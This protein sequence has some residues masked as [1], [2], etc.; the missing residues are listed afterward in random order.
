MRSAGQ[1]EDLSR[2]LIIGA[3]R[4]G[5]AAALLA[6]RM[7]PQV[8]IV[9]C[10]RQLDPGT[11]AALATLE[12]AKVKLKLGKEDNTLLDGC[13]LVI[14]SP[15]VPPDISL[16]GEARRR[17]IP[18]WGEVEFAWRF[19]ENPV[20]GV[21][22]TNGK[23]TTTELIGH[24]LKT[25]GWACRV[26]GNVGT[27]LSS[28]VGEMGGDEIVVLELSSFQLEDCIDFRPEI[29]ILLN[30]TEDHLNRHPTAKQYFSSKINIFVNQG[31][32]DIAILNLDDLTVRQTRIPG[33]AARVW[34]SL[35]WDSGASAAEPAGSGVM[36]A[37]LVFVK[38]SAIWADVA[39]LAA[40]GNSLRA[41]LYGSAP[42][43]NR[44]SLPT[45]GRNACGSGED[46][47]EGLAKVISWSEAALRGE[48]NLENSLAATAVCLSLGLSP[49][50]VAA[51]LKS[52]PGVPHRLQ[53]VAVINGVVYVND[54]KATNVDAALKALTA[55]RGGIHL[56]LG[57]SL[58]GCSFDPL[59]QAASREKV[60]EVIA[61][62]QA[63]REIAAS[64]RRAGREIAIV[65]T[66][67]EAVKM[68]AAR[69][70]PGDVVLLA[71]ACAS[72]DQYE[73]FEERGEHF[74]SLVNE[75]MPS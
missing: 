69:A 44:Q 55:F 16:I 25:S 48:H 41:R 59:A 23:T 66:L 51:A 8:E 65:D 1:L 20:I 33:Q 19:L 3:A 9:V 72:F 22:G 53:Q 71:P 15:G 18:V 60:K 49:G 47:Q 24:I 64:F 50:Q 42:G 11:P 73:S 27:A 68:A 74:I 6:R 37:P 57:G 34:F 32:E 14:K 63:A 54:S 13:N 5:R 35:R 61:M 29:A 62:G 2:L 7:L 46:S 75:M 12:E 17:G 26:A 67:N 45:S 56:I 36:P 43:G 52:F 30:L 39:G 58:K 40:A 10:D 31:P 38:E 70:V 4:S 28:L 21:T